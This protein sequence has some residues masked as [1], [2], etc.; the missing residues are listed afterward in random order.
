MVTEAKAHRAREKQNKEEIAREIAREQLLEGEEGEDEDNE[1]RTMREQRLKQ[2]KNAH[3]EKLEN[4]G[5]G[6]GQYREIVQDEFLKEVTGSFRVVCQFYHREFP[7][8]AIM[9]H[10][11]KILSERHIETKFIKIDAEKTPFFVDKLKIFRMPTLCLF[12]D[13]ICYDKI[14][15]FDGVSDMMPVGKEDEFPTIMLARQLGMRMAIDKSKIVDDDEKEANLIAKME[16]MRQKGLSEMMQ[17]RLED[18]D[19]DFDDL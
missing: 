6:H 2:L 18:E 11:L 15:G 10:H 12:N 1:L 9:D 13:G 14:I 3:R 5:K 19:D 17:S 8:C 16:A 4:I 7:R